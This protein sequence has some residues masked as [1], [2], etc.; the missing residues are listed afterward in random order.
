MGRSYVGSVAHL[1]GACW[2]EFDAGRRTER[3]FCR[4]EYFD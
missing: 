2:F 3:G 1:L 4:V